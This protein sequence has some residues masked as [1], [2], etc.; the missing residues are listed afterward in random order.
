MIKINLHYC[1]IL[2]QPMP[3]EIADPTILSLYPQ[4]DLQR[5]ITHCRGSQKTHQS[6]IFW[7]FR[8]DL[9]SIFR[10]KHLLQPKSCYP[11]SAS[12][13]FSAYRTFM[14]IFLWLRAI[15]FY[16]CEPL[17]RKTQ[18][19]RLR[20]LLFLEKWEKWRNPLEWVNAVVLKM[21]N[22]YRQQPAQK[23]LIFPFKHISKF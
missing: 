14:K 12:E 22:R 5:L 18:L 3:S 13:C 6:T 15:L 21:V 11:S 16:F 17:N 23:G 2:W 10:G 8:Y 7:L 9:P 1:S 4:N 19:V 20:V